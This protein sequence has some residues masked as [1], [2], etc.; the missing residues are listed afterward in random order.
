[1]HVR[2]GLIKEVRRS[3]GPRRG[4]GGDLEAPGVAVVRELCERRGP[5][6]DPRAPLE[7]GILYFEST[8]VSSATALQLPGS[9][10]GVLETVR[11]NPV[12]RG[13]CERLSD[14]VNSPPKR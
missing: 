11:G 13:R 6:P 5:A 9:Q 1:M 3:Q 4:G 7:K 14:Y 8:K 10:R 12:R 2:G